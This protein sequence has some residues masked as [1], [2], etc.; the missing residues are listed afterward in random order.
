VDP[1]ALVAVLLVAGGGLLAAGA[2]RKAVGSRARSTWRDAFREAGVSL[3]AA[4]ESGTRL[5]GTRGSL[6]VDIESD[7]AAVRVSVIGFDSSVSC[8]PRTQFDS[9]AGLETD[10]VLG[11]PRFDAAV[12]L[13][14]S[15]AV[16]RALLDHDTRRA[17]RDV[18]AGELRFEGDAGTETLSGYGQVA[19]GAIQLT[20]PRDGRDLFAR[21]KHP[22]L[23]PGALR[24]IIDLAERLMPPADPARRIADG[25]RP[26]PL[27]S[28]RL[29]NLRFLARQF[30]AHPAT[31]PAVIAAL[32]D[33]A[34]DVRLAAARHVGDEG[35]RTLLRIALAPASFE[36]HAVEAI[37]LLGDRFTPRHARWLLH[38]AAASRRLNIVAA[39]LAR[40]VRAADGRCVTAVARALGSDD[41]K[42]A[43]AAANALARAEAPGFEEAL[44]A[45]LEHRL[46][47]V[48]AEAVTTLGRVGSVRAV[49]PLRDWESRHGLDRWFRADARRAIAQIQSRLADASPGQLS[50]AEAEAGQVSLVKEDERG[51]VTVAKG[52]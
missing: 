15:E 11:D 47:V 16:L 26:E 29:A 38:R 35:A 22:G 37:A 51:R 13:R 40:L 46:P 42:V 27:A 32:D 6:Q 2:W 7:A 50:M 14:G 4:R 1:F 45:A 9:G 5:V 41:D 28:V 44:I 31:R 18:I 23:A 34:D 36:A 19:G 8:I 12:V 43:Q 33:E 17:L 48:Q 52:V 30:P 21:V 49:A 24:P 3:S 25:M 39:S 10:L 20:F